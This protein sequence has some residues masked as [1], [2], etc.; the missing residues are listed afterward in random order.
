MDLKKH[1]TTVMFQLHDFLYSVFQLLQEYGVNLKPE[2]D[3]PLYI[4]GLPIKDLATEAHLY[5][6]MALTVP[7]NHYAW[8]RWNLL[9][10]PEKLVIQYKEKIG[11]QPSKVS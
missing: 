8:S 3:S 1:K 10:G 5:R 11:A 9:A 7:S 6:T 4:E 2:A